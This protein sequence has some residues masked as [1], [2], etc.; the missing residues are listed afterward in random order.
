MYNVGNGSGNL[1]AKTGLVFCGGSVILGVLAWYWIPETRGLS[2]E[3]L[4]ALYES[5]LQPRRFGK[6][7][8]EERL[9]EVE[10]RKSEGSEKIQEDL[11][12]E[13]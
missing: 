11:G 13:M 9:S 3:V 7:D 6:V 12:I 8:V 5:G 1:G 10:L 4:G 2:T